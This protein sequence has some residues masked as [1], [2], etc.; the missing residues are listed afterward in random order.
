MDVLF[1]DT[2]EETLFFGKAQMQY[3]TVMYPTCS[4]MHIC[5]LW[6]VDDL[7]GDIVSV[8]VNV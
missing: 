6:K 1:L 7:V 2:L 4:L 5:C 8:H 3:L